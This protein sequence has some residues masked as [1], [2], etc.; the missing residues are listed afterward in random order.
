MA[1]SS[2]KKVWQ[3]S[4][5]NVSRSWRTEDAVE[6][7]TSDCIPIILAPVYLIAEMGKI[8]R[9]ELHEN[10][11]K[12]QEILEELALYFERIPWPLL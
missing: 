3:P 4:P 1:G 8:T 5:E 12:A 2:E 7:K 10:P 9:Q 11:A 6:L